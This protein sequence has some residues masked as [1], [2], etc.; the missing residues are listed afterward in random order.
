MRQ[1][2]GGGAAPGAPA[3]VTVLP[4]TPP[5]R[6]R[7]SELHKFNAV[8]LAVENESG[9]TFSHQQ[10]RRKVQCVPGP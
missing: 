2:G 6:L 3:G 5:R 7:G 10:Q 9:L 1:R 8:R 4:R